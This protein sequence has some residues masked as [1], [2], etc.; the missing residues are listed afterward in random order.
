MNDATS[1]LEAVGVT[2]RDLEGNVRPV[3]DIL[4]DL[5]S[6]WTSL[7]DE[8][9]QNT[10]VSVA[11]R[12]QLSRFLALM[13][14]WQI[15]IDATNSALNSQGSSMREQETY[16]D[17]LQARINKLDNAWAAFSLSVSEA[18]LTD[19]LILMIEGLKDLAKSSASFVDTFGVLPALFATIGVITVALSSKFRGL[20]TNLIFST[21]TMNRKTIAANALKTAMR[22]LAAATGVGVAFLGVGAIIEHLIG[23]YSQAKQAQEELR[24]ETEKLTT[25]YSESE[26]DIQSLA[27]QYEILSQKVKDGILPENDEEYLRVQQELSNLLPSLTEK[28]DGKGQAHLKSAEAVRQ[29]VEYLRELNNLEST[30]FIEEFSASIEEIN[31]KIADTRTQ[32]DALGVTERTQGN[33]QFR[34][35][36]EQT[37]EQNIQELIYKQQINAL[38]QEAINNAIRLGEA[39][40][41]QLGY[42]NLLLQSDRELINSYIQNNSHLL[43]TEQGIAGLQSRVQQ[44]TITLGNVRNV[45]GGAF[46]TEEIAAF[47]YKQ[48]EVFAVLSEAVRNG[49]TDWSKYKDQIKAAGLSFV[50]VLAGIVNKNAEVKEAMNGVAVYYDAAATQMVGSIEALHEAIESGQPIYDAQGNLIDE[51]SDSY[52]RLTDAINGNTGATWDNLSAAETLFGE[53]GKHISQIENAIQVVQLLSQAEN[54]NEQ[55]KAHL[56]NATA[57][58]AQMFPELNGQIANNIEWMI[59]EANMMN[60]VNNASGNMAVAMGANQSSATQAA[61]GAVNTRITAYNKEVDALHNLVAQR[62]Q[63]LN[64]IMADDVAGREVSP[65]FMRMYRTAN[66]QISKSYASLAT[67]ANHAVSAVRNFNDVYSASGGSGGG[68]GGSSGGSGGSGGRKSSGG[69]KSSKPKSS[70]SKSGSKSGSSASTKEEREVEIY[71]TDK[72]AQSMDNLNMKLEVSKHKQETMTETSKSYRTELSN[73]ITLMKEQQKLT[74]KEIARLES[75]NTSLNKQLKSLGSFNRLNADGKELYNEIKKEIDDNV[76][77]VN[78]LESQYRGLTSSIRDTQKQI[79]SIYETFAD[80]V[81][82]LY[83]QAYEKQRDLAVKANDK[84]MKML[85]DSHRRKMELKDEEIAKYEEVINAKLKEIDQEES[86]RSYEE[87]LA[88]KQKARQEL[89]TKINLLSMDDSLAARKQVSD[90]TVQLEIQ[91]KDIQDFM[92]NRALDLR[93]QSLNEELEAVR[94]KVNAEKELEQEKYDSEREKLEQKREDITRHWENVLND[95]RAFAKIREQILAGNVNGIKNQLMKFTTDMQKNMDVLG[96]SITQNLI[97]K[98]REATNVIKQLDKSHKEYAQTQSGKKSSG[99]SSNSKS[100]G[101]SSGSKSSGGSVSASGLPLRRKS[102]GFATPAGGWDKNSVT[103]WIKSKG[104]HADFS[105]RDALFQALKGNGYYTGTNSQNTWLMSQLKKVTGLKS[106]GYVDWDGNGGKLAFLHKKELVLNQG[107]TSN[108]LKGMDML[109]GIKD[110]FYKP[111]MKIPEAP[112]NNKQQGNTFKIENL[113]NIERFNGSKQDYNKLDNHLID[114]LE[115]LGVVTNKI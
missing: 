29:E 55:Q 22:G 16:A 70:S 48:Q 37:P 84:E 79:K 39:Y 57:F 20:A 90:L 33:K 97:D 41:G 4:G 54:L 13:N 51:N 72:Y 43:Q 50:D 95:E 2:I 86:N 108:F 58:L 104:Y 44:Y 34:I 21:T 56:S 23:K 3:Q 114:A 26:N 81:I 101:S 35:E 76:K 40:A 17:S 107:D 77:S 100:S 91:D 60:Q 32:I 69:S 65:E 5:A 18:V 36:R 68:S 73:Q 59:A 88:E 24:V 53:R 42:K 113:L 9:R 82:D 89:Q 83:K 63:A 109:K 14:N 25:S 38:E 74:T 80:E 19:S 103:D 64:A 46:S 93:K 87:Q 96:E 7:S 30:K 28:V 12:Y 27:S 106:G 11:G 105:D 1:S 85:E 115:D 66:I 94:E 67:S 62:Q 99:S 78:Q 47:G 112:Q 111:F 110:M 71:V 92:R 98:L 31:Q 52:N 10:A 61:V 15:S 45:V 8:Q 6:K 102:G 49:E 75:R